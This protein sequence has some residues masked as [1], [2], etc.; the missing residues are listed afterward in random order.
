MVDKTGPEIMDEIIQEPTIDRFLDRS[1]YAEP[2]TDAELA[3]LVA[4]MRRDRVT[5]NMKEDKKAAKK[6]GIDDPE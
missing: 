6:E 3:E 2:L 1:P 5:W 4:A